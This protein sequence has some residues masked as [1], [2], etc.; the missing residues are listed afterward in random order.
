MC[1]GVRF[2]RESSDRQGAATHSDVSC[3]PSENVSRNGANHKS[4]DASTTML[5]PTALRGTI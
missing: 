1:L 5:G 4:F 3:T 2:L